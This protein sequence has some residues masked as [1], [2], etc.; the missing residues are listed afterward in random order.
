MLV[1]AYTWAQDEASCT[2]SVSMPSSAAASR[3]TRVEC[4]EAM[5]KVTCPPYF[6]QVV[7]LFDPSR[8]AQST[9]R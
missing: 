7:A 8:L 3:N 6:L 4:T 2:L 5:I 1:P 9:Y